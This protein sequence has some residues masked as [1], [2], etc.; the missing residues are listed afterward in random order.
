MDITTLDDKK[1]ALIKD[2]FLFE[3][4]DTD[5]VNSILRS[6]QCKTANYNK[7][8]VIFSPENFERC[9]AVV[10]D[11]SILVSKKKQPAPADNERA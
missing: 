2:I 3:G 9:I 5:F 10:L 4:M 8:A 7:G 11:G 1:L 6:P